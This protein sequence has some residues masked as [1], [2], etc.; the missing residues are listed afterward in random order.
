MVVHPIGAKATKNGV[1]AEELHPELQST[2]WMELKP[3]VY[4]DEKINDVNEI[5]K[6]MKECASFIS[7]KEVRSYKSFFKQLVDMFHVLAFNALKGTA[8]CFKSVVKCEHIV[9][10]WN[11]AI[12]NFHVIEEYKEHVLSHFVTARLPTLFLDYV[13]TMLSIKPTNPVRTL[14]DF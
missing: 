2:N 11:D 1:E 4:D 8:A 12:T 6:L 10:L 13:E 3:M 7:K 9:K 5:H 14:Y